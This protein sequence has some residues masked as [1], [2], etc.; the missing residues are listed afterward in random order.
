MP[1]RRSLN[2]SD[3]TVYDFDL[4]GEESSSPTQ[5]DLPHPQKRTSLSKPVMS[6]LCRKQ[7]LDASFDQLVSA[8]LQRHWNGKTERLRGPEVD[9]ELDFRGLLNR[10][11][12]WLFPLRIRPV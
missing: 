8:A 7:T 12:G 5:D 1:R 2:R 11:I 3:A 9:D 4:I 10:Q 6:A